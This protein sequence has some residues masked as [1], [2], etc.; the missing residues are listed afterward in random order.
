[1]GG[2]RDASA[3]SRSRFQTALRASRLFVLVPVVVLLLAS[4]GAFAYG[5]ELF[6]LTVGEVLDN[7]L[8]VGHKIGDLLLVIDLFLI[9]ATMLIAAFGFYELFVGRLHDGDASRLPA[10]LQMRDLND[11]KVRVAGMLVLIAA[12]DFVEV[13][14][15]S[16]DGLRTL[17]R[18][19]GVAVVILALTLFQR[20]SGAHGQSQQDR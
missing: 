12:V 7:A 15:D 3:R 18:G 1:M 11:L 13:L 20:S 6:V 10:W 4:L 2:R 14:V 16:T 9:G 5:A 17:E 8:P 19:A